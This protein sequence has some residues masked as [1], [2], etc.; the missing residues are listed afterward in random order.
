[1]EDEDEDEAEDS[2]MDFRTIGR[3]PATSN[4]NRA[5]VSSFLFE[6]WWSDI[7]FHL[8]LMLL[9]ILITFHSPTVIQ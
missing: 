8:N 7:P 3:S 1:M 9:F 4:I 2:D 5:F 6:M